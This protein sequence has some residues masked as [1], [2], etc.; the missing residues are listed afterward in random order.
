MGY[1]NFKHLYRKGLTDLEFIL[2]TKVFQKDFHLISE[3][4]NATISKLV[5]E[6]LLTYL[7]G[8]DG[9]LASLRFTAKASD[10][11]RELEIFEFD[12]RV[13][14]LEDRLIKLY[15]L[16]NK[17]IGIKAKV[18]ENLMWFINKTGFGVDVVYKIIEDYLNDCIR[19]QK[20]VM[21]LENLIWKQP[22]VFSVHRS[23]KD[24]V[25]F[26]II[27]RR[28]GLG[29]AERFT[30]K[31]GAVYEWLFDLSKVTPPKRMNKSLRITGS[32]EGDVEFLKVIKKELL[33][34]ISKNEEETNE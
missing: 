21:Y 10:F 16:N 1:I 13:V 28:Y 12:E 30:N 3:S 33:N 19:N 23:L 6:G 5:E 2:L 9:E 32:Y 20:N 8:K 4:D 15:E 11:F 17:L 27:S 14:D 29:D 7:K 24:S 26:D 25:L 31:K 34:V 22:S 18:R